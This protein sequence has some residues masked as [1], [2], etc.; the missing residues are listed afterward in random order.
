MIDGAGVID[1]GGQRWWEVRGRPGW[2][3]TAKRRSSSAKRGVRACQQF[4]KG[5]QC[6]A[7]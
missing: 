5:K 6:P 4:Y 2:R 7:E 3:G 1:G